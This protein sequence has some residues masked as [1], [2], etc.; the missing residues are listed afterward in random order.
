MS[1]NEIKSVET[2]PLK[3]SVSRPKRSDKKYG[4]I[5]AI[6]TCIIVRPPHN[7]GTVDLTAFAV[8]VHR[9]ARRRLTYPN[10]GRAGRWRNRERARLQSS[11]CLLVLRLT[12]CWHSSAVSK[13]VCLS[14]P[15]VP[16][17]YNN[18]ITHSLSSL[19]MLNFL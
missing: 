19:A 3:K 16:R 13:L 5:S 12:C 9:T 18:R 4:R 2:V 8:L 7:L 11:L 14:L 10:L 1:L 6:L 15:F 17:E